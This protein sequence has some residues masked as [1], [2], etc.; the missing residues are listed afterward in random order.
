MD[1]AW[2]PC[3]RVC[4]GGKLKEISGFTQQEMEELNMK[5]NLLKS[6]IKSQID[7]QIWR[8]VL[9]CSYWNQQKISYGSFVKHTVMLMKTPMKLPWKLA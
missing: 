5:R 7:C 1:D 9:K 3:V 4:G 2:V 6:Q 8:D